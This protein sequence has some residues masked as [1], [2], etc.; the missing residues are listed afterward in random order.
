MAHCF[1]VEYQN[2]P[3]ARATSY[4]LYGSAFKAVRSTYLTLDADTAMGD[5]IRRDR[6]LVLKTGCITVC[7]QVGFAMATI[8]Y[9]E[10]L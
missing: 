7:A 6:D 3:T 4:S 2:T 10:I 5:N 1:K 8:T 9:E